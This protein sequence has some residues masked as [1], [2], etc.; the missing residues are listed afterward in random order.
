M[1]AAS[2]CKYAVLLLASVYIIL[3]LGN[4]TPPVWFGTSLLPVYFNI[5]ISPKP[6][7]IIVNKDITACVTT[8]SC[9]L[10]LFNNTAPSDLHYNCIIDLLVPYFPFRVI[11]SSGQKRKEGR[12][13][14]AVV[15][16]FYTAPS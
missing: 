3:S 6:A 16:L 8:V 13:E 4:P 2:G 12:Q 7:L 9:L 14:E 15:Y 10:H 5:E 1:Q 11:V